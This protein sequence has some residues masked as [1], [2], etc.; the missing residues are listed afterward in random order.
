M[1]K[2]LFCR[3]LHNR[4]AQHDENARLGERGPTHRPPSP[5]V[6]LYLLLITILFLLFGF[7]RESI[8]SSQPLAQPEQLQMATVT[9]QLFAKMPLLIVTQSQKNLKKILP[10]FQHDLEFTNQFVVKI[11]PSQNE[12][13]IKKSS[14]A[15]WAEEGYPLVLLLEDKKDQ[16]IW[17]LYDTASI[18]MIKGQQ[19]SVSSKPNVTAHAL[20]DQ[21]WPALTGSSGF[22]SSKIAYS[23]MAH[24]RGRNIKRHLMMR[25]ATDMTGHSEEL[26]VNSP[27]ISVSPRWNKDLNSPIILYS[28]YTKSNVR[29]VAVNMEGKRSIVSNFDGV[30]MQVAYS[31]DGKEVVYCLSRPPLPHLP[32][33][34]T[35]QLYHY[36]VDDDG[37]PAVKRLTPLPGNNFAPCWGPGNTIFYATDLGSLGNPKI[38]WH[39]LKSGTITPITATGFA[40]S[41]T[42]SPSAHRLAYA[43]MVKGRMQLFLYDLDTKKEEQITFDNASKDEC[44]WSPC[45]NL[46]AFVAEQPNGKSRIGL[47]NVQTGEQKMITPTHEDC[48]Y[49]HWSPIYAQ[50]PMKS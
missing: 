25:D 48:C 38:H 20:A 4:S 13:E 37:R 32:S 23:K 35:T 5:F 47:F 24:R 8:C 3:L 9:A 46:L 14:F 33:H 11:A 2:K 19:L 42:Y 50:L 36:A 16:I 17:R 45:G 29:L 26:L 21:V 7:E 41:P 1:V 12:F 27:T 49:P 6:R 43:K 30:N 22:F 34:T 28:E 18:S 10:L 40:V 39:C 44:C 15:K 31:H